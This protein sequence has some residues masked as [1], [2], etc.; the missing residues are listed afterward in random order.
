MNTHCFNPCSNGMKK[1]QKRHNQYGDS[2][3]RFN[4]CSNGMKKEPTYVQTFT[5]RT[6]F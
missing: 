3:P 5:T 1:E 4:P 6:E 2:A